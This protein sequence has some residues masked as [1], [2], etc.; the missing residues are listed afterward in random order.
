M[1]QIRAVRSWLIE[2]EKVTVEW[3][4]ELSEIGNKPESK[5]LRF[6]VPPTSNIN[7]SIKKAGNLRRQKLRWLCKRSKFSAN[8][9]G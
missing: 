6:P 2:T 3:V 1:V 8:S 9:G 5:N 4:T 7:R